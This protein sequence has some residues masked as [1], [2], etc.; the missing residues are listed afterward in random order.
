M[1]HTLSLLSG[2]LLLAQAAPA[3]DLLMFDASTF[4][5]AVLS[6]NQSALA[7]AELEAQIGD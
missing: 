1:K 2:L 4:G 6:R 3:Q 7:G 5:N